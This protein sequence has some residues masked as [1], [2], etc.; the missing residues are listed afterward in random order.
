MMAIRSLF[1]GGTFTGWHMLVVM[2]LFFGTIISV[3]VTMAYLATSSWSGLIVKNTYVASQQFDE[4]VAETRE[5]KSQG[6]SSRI[7][8]NSGLVRYELTDN[9][10]M[11]VPADTVTATLSRPADEAHDQTFVLKRTG[12]GNYSA[13]AEL[14]SGQWL[15]QIVTSRGGDVVY[16]EVQRIFIETPGAD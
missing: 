16:R 11:A 1:Q 4:D 13:P 14:N 2:V 9:A 3:N 7:S 8:V 15:I 6:W 5:M 10:G 12:E